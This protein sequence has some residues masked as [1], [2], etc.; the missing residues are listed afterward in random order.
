MIR[1]TIILAAVAALAFSAP[2]PEVPENYDDIPA[3]YKSLIPAEVSEH[4]KSITPE[5]KAILKEVA[6]GYK[7]F[8]SEDDVSL[9]IE[10]SRP[11]IKILNC[12]S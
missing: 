9:K 8:K 11:I 1:A 12:S 4:L 6:K 2:V 7:D 3:E 10:N 5:E